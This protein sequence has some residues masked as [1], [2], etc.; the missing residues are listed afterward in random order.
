MIIHTVSPVMIV[1]SPTI[2]RSAKIQLNQIPRI[3]VTKAGTGMK[4]ASSAPNAITHWWKSLL[5]PRMSAC[6]AQ[7]AILTSAPLSA[8]IA[9]GPSCLVPAKW[10]L[11]E[12]TGMK[13]A[14]CVS[15]AD[16]Q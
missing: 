7:S 13:P 1:S 4:D 3:F 5:L 16:N 6:Y 14:L 11:R 9:R 2:V 15:I 8:S 10:N 12:T